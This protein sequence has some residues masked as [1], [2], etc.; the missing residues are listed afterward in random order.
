M[1]L[2]YITGISGSGKSAVCDELVAR[3]YE[4]HEGDDNLSAFYHT[5]SGKKV[6]RPTTV[7]DRT[8]EWREQH[9]WKMSRDKLLSLKERAVA[10]P[11]FVC[12]VASNEEEYLDVFDKVF[13]LMLDTET[14]KE[15]IT[16]RTNNDFGKSEHEMTTLLNWQESTEEFYRKVGVRVIDA[17]QPISVV[18]DT[19]LSEI[20]AAD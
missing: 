10:K 4:A 7:I 6:N 13:A 14:L 5:Q 1:S 9:T 18:V 11:V 16:T 20:G 3:G 17:T 8:P 12:G 19:I 2:F 15:R